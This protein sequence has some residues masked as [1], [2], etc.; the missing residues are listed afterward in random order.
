MDSGYKMSDEVETVR[1]TGELTVGHASELKALLRKALQGSSGRI[2]IK[3]EDVTA[4]DLSCLQLL[5]SAH[6]TASVM[7]SRLRL[8]GERPALFCQTMRAAGFTRQRG[9]GLTPNTDCLW[10]GGEK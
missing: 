9:C 4:V 7:N 8:A 1:L 10:S 3:F 5:C 2:Q 6:R